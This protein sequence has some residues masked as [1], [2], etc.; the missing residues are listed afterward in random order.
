[1]NNYF[2]PPK[3]LKSIQPAIYDVL[4]NHNY[5]MPLNT[6]IDT[7]HKG[8]LWECHAIV[9]LTDANTLRQII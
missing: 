7:L 3:Y 1:M 5:L 8:K 4:I 6:R 2:I 9:P